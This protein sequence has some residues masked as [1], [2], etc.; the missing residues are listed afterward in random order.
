MDE[1][2]KSDTE[3]DAEEPDAPDAEEMTD[4]TG[5][6]SL[7]VASA[8][9]RDRNRKGS[10]IKKLLLGNNNNNDA[11]FHSTSAAEWV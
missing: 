8:A 3:L 10:P 11:N 6:L 2:S 7:R 9:E 4:E 5:A 1:G